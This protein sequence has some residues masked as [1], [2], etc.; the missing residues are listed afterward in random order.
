MPF[1]NF[2][3][4]TTFCS[5]CVSRSP[6]PANR[7]VENFL[8]LQQ[9]VFFIWMHCL[10][11]DPILLISFFNICNLNPRAIESQLLDRGVFYDQS[12]SWSCI[13]H[14]FINTTKL[15]WKNP[16]EQKNNQPN[17][18]KQHCCV[19]QVIEKESSNKNLTFRILWPRMDLLGE[20]TDLTH[21]VKT[22][23][24]VILTSNLFFISLF[25]DALFLLIHFQP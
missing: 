24:A 11:A 22:P 12:P 16:I 25:V 4:E 9:T 21:M 17:S 8:L 1:L 13:I 6:C 3:P 20:G 10:S 2:N 15:L 19:V 18:N 7:Y 14:V 23:I 5:L